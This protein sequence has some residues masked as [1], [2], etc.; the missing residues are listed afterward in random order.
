[1]RRDRLGPM[2][3]RPRKKKRPADPGSEASAEEPP[4]PRKR[5]REPKSSSE[6]ESD[7]E[8]PRKTRGGSGSAE[9]R[10]RKRRRPD[11]ADSTSDMVSDLDSASEGDAGPPGASLGELSADLSSR[12]ARKR[13]A[14]AHGLGKLGAKA[15]SAVPGLARLLG[16]EEERVRMRAARAIGKIGPAASAAVPALAQVLNQGSKGDE[17]SL[18][19]VAVRAL[20]RIGPGV[21]PGLL[22]A[23]DEPE[24]RKRVGRV[25]ASIEPRPEPET[26]AAVEALLEPGREEA[27]EL[28]LSVLKRHGA[29][30]V[31]LILPF[32]GADDAPDL[33]DLAEETLQGMGKEVAAGLASALGA[34]D[35]ALRLAAARSLTRIAQEVS[36]RAVAK[37]CSRLEEALSDADISVRLQ[38]VEALGALSE[39]ATRAEPA[40][41]QALGDEESRVSLAAVMALL[42]LAADK[43]KL[44]ERMVEVLQ[45]ERGEFIRVGACMVLMHLGPV[46]KHSVP[47]LLKAVEDRATEVREYAHLALQ[48]IRTPSMR[49]SVIR[50]ASLRLK[51]VDEDEEEDDEDDEEEEGSAEEGSA[52]EGAPEGPRAPRKRRRAGLRPRRVRRKR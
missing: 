33:Q 18:A 20:K 49:V 48:A 28:V 35:A 25:L 47:A 24:L 7:E 37:V 50:T 39:Y 52:E 45:E 8:R 2:S 3:E 40:L 44:A 9:E 27:A 38:V 13:E 15:R 5:S 43:N 36:Q 26:L 42:D 17:T 30:A 11:P 19:S 51:V 21:W 4:R 6:S 10:P 16:D 31:S 29:A 46:A 12:S 32:A 41:I 23:L 1:M 22:A 34:E 14:A